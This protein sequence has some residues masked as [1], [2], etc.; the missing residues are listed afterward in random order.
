M[1]GIYTYI[2]PQLIEDLMHGEADREQ[3]QKA[4]RLLDEALTAYWDA[5][6]ARESLESE[7]QSISD[8]VDRLRTELDAAIRER[9]QWRSSSSG[10]NEFGDVE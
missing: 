1:K 4:V 3:Q 5:E 7:L 9:D 8:K 6:K 10:L 2:G